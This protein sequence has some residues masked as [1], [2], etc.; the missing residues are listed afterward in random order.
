[1]GKYNLNIN[2]LCVP[3]QNRNEGSFVVRL[4]VIKTNPRYVQ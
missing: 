1:M 4:S 2:Q 3:L